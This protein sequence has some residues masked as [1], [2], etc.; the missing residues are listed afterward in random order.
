[1]ALK[2][3]ANLQDIPVGA[4]KHIEVENREILLANVEGTVYAIDDRCGHM[5]AP[6][7]RGTLRGRII[8]CALHHAQFDVTTG[9]RIRDA[10]MGG[11]KGALIATTTGKLMTSVKTYDRQAYEVAVE[12]DTISINF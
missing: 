10:Q 6:L 5:S 4:L 7:S 1:M 12:G 2:E 3:V 11:L 9:K 8:E